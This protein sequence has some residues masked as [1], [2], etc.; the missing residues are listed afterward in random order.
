MTRGTVALCA[1]VA[2]VAGCIAPQAARRRAL[3]A[4]PPSAILAALAR[5]EDATR[6]LRLSMTV[7]LAGTD[8]ASPLPSPAYLAIDSTGAIRLQVLSAFGMTVLDL[9][10]HGD[11][12]TLDL[13]LRRQTTDGTIDLR[14]LTDPT[15]AVSD[16]MIVALA[17]LFRPK[18]RA[19]ACSGAAPATV[20]CKVGPTLVARVT[21]DERLRPLREEYV[22]DDGSRLLVAT[23]DDYRGDDPNASPGSLLIEDPASGASMA[24]RVQRVRRAA[25][26]RS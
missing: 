6:G 11:S 25:A 4:A 8:H 23:Y 15:V 5:R 2:L 3:H 18:A 10:I 20:A 9:A 17:L 13:P 24:I 1:L 19:D 26:P 22:R 12:Y 16:R 14:T 21:V 7:R